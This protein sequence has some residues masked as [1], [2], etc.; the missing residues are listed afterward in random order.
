MGDRIDFWGTVDLVGI[1]LVNTYY[2]DEAENI[3]VL[4]VERFPLELGAKRDTSS[5]NLLNRFR[6]GMLEIIENGTYMNILKKYYG[7][8]VPASIPVTKKET[9]PSID[10][11][12]MNVIDLYHAR[13]LRRRLHR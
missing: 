11:G 3:G 5:G 8:N 10:S 9:R 4:D 1:S 7:D 12:M 13:K 2:P 6:S